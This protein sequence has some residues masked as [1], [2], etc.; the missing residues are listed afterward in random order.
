M[1][2]PAGMCDWWKNQMKRN[3]LRAFTYTE[4]LKRIACVEGMW[5]GIYGKRKCT[6]DPEST[7]PRHIHAICKYP[8]SHPPFKRIPFLFLLKIDGVMVIVMEHDNAKME[9]V[10][11]ESN[12]G[13]TF[14][15]DIENS[16]RT[17]KSWNIE[18][19]GMYK[20]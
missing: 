10:L 20:F 11:G 4:K 7:T 12:D 6:S 1:E 15:S 19:L 8:T 18:K 14:G 3:D 5:L 17:S 13:C 2:H 16:I 9:V